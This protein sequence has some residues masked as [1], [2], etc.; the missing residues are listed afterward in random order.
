MPTVHTVPPHATPATLDSVLSEFLKLHVYFSSNYLKLHSW[1][2]Q[3][4]QLIGEDRQINTYV[5]G[6]F[7]E[8]EVS[9]DYTV[10]PCIKKPQTKPN[11]NPKKQTPA[12]KCK[13]MNLEKSEYGT[14]I[15]YRRNLPGA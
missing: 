2:R 12:S 10:K 8:F 13:P 3:H 15:N 1:H 6:G 11:Q 9:L 14:E 4:R 7:L 5:K